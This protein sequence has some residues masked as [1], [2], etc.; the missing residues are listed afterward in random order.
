MQNMNC[1]KSNQN[2]HNCMGVQNGGSILIQN[3]H[4]GTK[5]IGTNRVS[6]LFW[7]KLY[8]KIGIFRLKI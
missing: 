2:A 4:V 3:V 6:S 7:P 5:T 8:R 1:K